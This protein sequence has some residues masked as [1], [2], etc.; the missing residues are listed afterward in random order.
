MWVTACKKTALSLFSLPL[1]ASVRWAEKT[2][3]SC[4]GKDPKGP[5]SSCS[6][7]SELG[8]LTVHF[9]PL[10]VLGHAS[11]EML[12]LTNVPPSSWDDLGQVLKGLLQTG[13]VVAP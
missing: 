11:Q 4:S 7:R 12:R 8:Q 9:Q 5:D 13:M 3:F 2:L 6:Q 10:L 1:G